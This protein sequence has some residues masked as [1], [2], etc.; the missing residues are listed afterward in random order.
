[1]APEERANRLAELIPYTAREA[2]DGPI[3]WSPFALALIDTAPDP[4]PDLHR[5]ERK[6]FTGTS[7]G[8]F[9]GRFVRRRPLVA[10][11]REHSDVR[12]RT[13]ARKAG[14]ALEEN[15]WRW[16]EHDRERES[17]FE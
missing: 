14:K 5:F 11:M 15:I 13:W 4:V 9:S 17:R 16:D 6:F 3:V 10:A 7:S 2:E 12:V 1:M 8:P